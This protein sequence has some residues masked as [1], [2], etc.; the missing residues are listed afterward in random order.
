MEILFNAA[1]Y[2]IEFF[3]GMLTFTA[4][5]VARRRGLGAPPGLDLA[6]LAVTIAVFRFG[7]IMP[8]LTKAAAFALVVLILAFE[9]GTLSRLLKHPACL[10]LGTISYSIYLTHAV[11]V[12]LVS[13]AIYA[14][15]AR[16]GLPITTPIGGDDVI[17]LGGPWVEDALALGLVVVVIASSNLTYRYVEDPARRWFNR[18]SAG[19]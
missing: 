11:Y 9:R 5:Q 10:R 15:G 18:V 6:A 8:P 1:E 16:L 14:V 2:A 4:F 19:R 3:V 12:S 13:I 7:D 17:T